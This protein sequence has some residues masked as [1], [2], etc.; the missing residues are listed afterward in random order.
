MKMMVK[1]YKSYDSSRTKTLVE[2]VIES[3]TIKL[4]DRKQMNKC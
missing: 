1:D 4:I 3:T 2:E